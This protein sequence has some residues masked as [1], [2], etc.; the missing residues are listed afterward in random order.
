MTPDKDFTAL[1]K[2][3]RE[4]LKTALIDMENK[5]F[6]DSI[7]RSYYAVYHA[8]SA[9]LLSK[10]LVFSSHNQTIGA[11][12]KEFIRQGIFKKEFTKIIQSMFE[13]R[14]S[15]DYDAYFES[16]E[17]QAKKHYDNAGIIIES[18]KEYLDRWN[19]TAH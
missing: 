15:G 9:C 17:G 6:E 4:K 10:D 16:D 1:L 8:I 2:K 12:N 7:S 3:A 14:Q 11:F 19:G 18:I 13:D 5:R